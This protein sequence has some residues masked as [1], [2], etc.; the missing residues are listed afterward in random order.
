ML[1][2]WKR[3]WIRWGPASVLCVF[4]ALFPVLM[5]YAVDPSSHYPPCKAG[6]NSQNANCYKEGVSTLSRLRVA[7]GGW[8]YDNRDDIT[9]GSTF[10][11]AI[12]TV[13]LWF[14]TRGLGHAAKGQI[15][16]AK[17]TDASVRTASCN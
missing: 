16:E 8:I 14:A 10:V 17:A 5:W 9:A 1:K 2:R 4:C 7:I 12:F 6:E 13:T 11:I 3:R 15:S